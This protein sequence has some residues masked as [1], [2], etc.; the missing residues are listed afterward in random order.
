MIKLIKNSFY[1]DY[2]NRSNKG[3][4][5]VEVEL[6]TPDSM[7]QKTMHACVDR[8]VAD[9]L[10]QITSDGIEHRSDVK[11]YDAGNGIHEEKGAMDDPE[12]I[13]QTRRLVENWNTKVGDQSSPISEEAPK[14][15][16][17]PKLYTAEDILQAAK[18][19]INAVPSGTSERKVTVKTMLK[20][21]FGVD[22]LKDLPEVEYLRFIN[23]LKAA[24]KD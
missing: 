6:D 14:A 4:L 22:K 15:P 19:F 7:T 24:Q 17:E 9:L 1:I 5:A 10:K 11:E 18:D 23:A 21:D 3:K 8:F 16:E 20:N 12:V 13:E 2:M